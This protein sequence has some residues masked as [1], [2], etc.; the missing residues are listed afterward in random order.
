MKR[1]L[2]CIILFLSIICQG[3][4]EVDNAYNLLQDLEDETQSSIEDL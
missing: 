4:Y 1:E 2:I 3:Q